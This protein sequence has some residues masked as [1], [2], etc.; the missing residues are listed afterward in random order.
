MSSKIKI[1]DLI[2]ENRFFLAPMAGITN[3]PFRL[4]VKR[5]G[6]SLV[7]TEMISA[8]GLCYNQKRTHEYLAHTPEEKPISIQIFGSE[9]DVMA[10]AARIA[11]EAGADMIDI[12][13]G[14]PAKK[15]VKTGAGG[16]LLKD[17][18]KAEQIIK[19]VRKVC[20]IPLTTKIRAGWSPETP[21]FMEIARIAQD[22]GVDGIT[23]HPRFVTQG[24]SGKADWSIIAKIKEKIDIP[25]IG[26][27]D[28]FTARDAMHMIK[29]TGCDA[30]MIARGAIGNPWIFKDVLAL[31]RGELSSPPAFFERKSIM[32]EH[33]SLIKNF[34]GENRSLRYIR[35]IF[36]WYT[37]GFPY[38]GS[39]REKV[40]KINT[41]EELMALLNNY[42]SRLEGEGEGKGC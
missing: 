24:F 19:A 39:F 15:V 31:E 10:E 1:G 9:P 37:K 42:F 6:A 22:S 13:M 36:I 32:L 25:V 5:F 33:Y 12:N 41:E 26:N 29:E 34:I 28:V 20:S 16:A 3:M 14:C 40:T 21:V 11:I 8:K 27:G 38:S 17:L 30:V 4:I 35:G 18:K 7:T 23:I 2:L